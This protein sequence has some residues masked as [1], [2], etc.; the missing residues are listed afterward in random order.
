MNAI[1]VLK[2]LFQSGNGCCEETYYWPMEVFGVMTDHY[3][4]CV[5]GDKN[6]PLHDKNTDGEGSGDTFDEL[7]FNF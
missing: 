1:F 3:N 7:V 6:H 4:C 2:V 5:K